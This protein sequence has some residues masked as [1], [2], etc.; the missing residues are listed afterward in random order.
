MTQEQAEVNGVL[1]RVSLAVLDAPARRAALAPFGETV[2][3]EVEAIH[4]AAVSEPP[5]WG[6]EKDSGRSRVEAMLA[7][8][9]PWLSDR[10]RANLATAYLYNWK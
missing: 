9:Y 7:A 1:E 6:D 3:A 4:R 5:P 8:R 10:A 2:A